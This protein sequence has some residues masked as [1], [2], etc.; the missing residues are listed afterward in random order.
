[1]QSYPI[2]LALFDFVP[3]FAF[4]VGA[5]YLVKTC[6]ICSNRPNSRML[7]AGTLLIFVGGFSKA[8]WKFLVAAEIADIPWLGE[9]QFI[10]AGIGFLGMCVA[11]IY[12][13]RGRKQAPA[14]P[15][16]TMLAMAGWKIPFLFIMTVSSL[17]AEGILAYLAFRRKLRL[18]G[19]AFVIGVL[20]LLGMGAL[21]SA[22]QTI[23]MQWIAESVNT[24]G[25]SGFM[26]GSILL[27]R[28]YKTRGC[29]MA[30]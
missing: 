2:S 23:A 28:D 26:V 22:E 7:M 27:H 24:I 21:A 18:A 14:S 6:L 29:D 1:M 4:L 3:T 17:G 16:G 5:F 19:A 20:G 9:I 30:G 15:A 13:V 8:L 11:V 10:F 25:Q 12:M